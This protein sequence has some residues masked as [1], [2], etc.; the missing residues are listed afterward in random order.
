MRSRQNTGFFKSL[1]AALLLH[2]LV[3]LM[4]LTRPAPP[5]I[6]DTDSIEL[7]LVAYLPVPP[8]A[9]TLP[10]PVETP[11]TALE[12][13]PDL[14][15]NMAQTPAAPQ[16]TEPEPTRVTVQQA[17]PER[18][19]TDPAAV[20]LSRQFISETS[21]ADRLFGKPLV[22]NDPAAQGEFRFPVRQDMLAMLDKP[23]QDLPFAYTPGLVH[24]AYAPGVRGDLQR[25]WD[26]ITPEFGWRTD[27]GTEFRCILL[28]VVVGCGWK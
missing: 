24:F 20:I 10:E 7:E 9:V 4:P 15:D 17:E 25:F 6:N 14:E 3:L 23:M 21:E 13:L 27:N 2:A 12:P 19:S 26:V 22:I 16:P 18:V 8:A 5:V 11:E 1:A 28:L